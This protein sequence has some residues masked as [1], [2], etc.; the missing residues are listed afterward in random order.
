MSAIKSWISAMR[1]RTLPLA[2]SAI[3]LGIAMADLTYSANNTVALLCLATAICLQV[4]SNFANDYGDFT[5]GTDNEQRLG[6]MRALQSGNITIGQMRL[7][8]IVLVILSLASG[9]SLLYHATHG[10]I[11]VSFILFFILGLAAIVAAIKYTVGKN[12][13][14]YSGLGDVFVFLFFG[15]VSVIGTY[16]LCTGIQFSWASDWLVIVPSLAVGFLSTAVLNTNNIRDIDNDFASGKFTLPV[17]MGIHKARL[18]HSVLMSLAL[19]SWA[20]LVYFTYFHWVQLMVFPAMFWV[21]KTWRGVLTEEPSPAYNQYLKMLSL[22]T[23]LLVLVF[24]ATAFVA[25]IIMVSQ[26]FKALS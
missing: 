2:T 6:N 17:K 3:L 10:E 8:I 9:I 12:A 21:I 13:Y 19:L 16:I 26:L 14:G 23:F 18:Y 24:I 1:L 20:V 15:P 11:N 5:K 7:A 25:R 22:G 4:L